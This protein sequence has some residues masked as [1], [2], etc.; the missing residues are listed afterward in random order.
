[1]LRRNPRQITRAYFEERLD[2]RDVAT[3]RPDMPIHP[4]LT[5]RVAG[6]L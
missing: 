3:R 5:G 2:R 6:T 1:V 4:G